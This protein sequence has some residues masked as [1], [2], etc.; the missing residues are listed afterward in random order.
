MSAILAA[1]GDTFCFRT[2]PVAA[3]RIT[4]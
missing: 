4:V 2:K 1:G 3:P